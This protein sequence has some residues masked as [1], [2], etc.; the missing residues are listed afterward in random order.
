[1]GREER[2][3]TG[4]EGEEERA[5]REGEKEGQEERE[6]RRG[7]RVVNVKKKTHLYYNDKQ[8][9]AHVHV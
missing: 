1:M 3:R 7:R 6:R 2:E 8:E 9:Q 5:E 4:R